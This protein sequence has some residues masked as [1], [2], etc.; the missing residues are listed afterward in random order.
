[1]QDIGTVVPQHINIV[2]ADTRKHNE[3][4]S[5]SHFERFKKP[6]FASRNLTGQKKGKMSVIYIEPIPVFEKYEHPTSYVI[7][8]AIIPL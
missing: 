4:I 1:M 3:T 6:L 7:S 2:L 5:L 8:N